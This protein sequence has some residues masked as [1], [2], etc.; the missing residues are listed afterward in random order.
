MTMSATSPAETHDPRFP[1]GD[2]TPPE[3]I[4]PEDRRYAIL[5]LAEMP[6]QMREAVRDLDEEKINT[7]YREGGWTV[8]QVVHHVADSHSTAT[9]RLRKALTED[10][11]VVQGYNEAAF[12]ELADVASA[13]VEWSLETIESVHA[14]WVMLLQTFTD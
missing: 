8:R 2:F 1:I 7:P 12:A 3:S 13:P 11:P 9:F 10:W 5:V 14:R 6:E 4:T